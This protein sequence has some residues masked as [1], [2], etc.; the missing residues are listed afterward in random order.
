MSA[1]PGDVNPVAVTSVLLAN[2]RRFLELSRTRA[3]AAAKLPREILQAAFVRSLEKA[4]EIRE[5][6]NAVAWFYRLLRN[7]VV[8]HYRRNAASRRTLAGFAQHLQ[9]SV[10]PRSRDRNGHLRM[11]S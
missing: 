2:H 7:A 8:D 11:H 3:S 6:E 1:T 9:L 5:P 10:S 4:E